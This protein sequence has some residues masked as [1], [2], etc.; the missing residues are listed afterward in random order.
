MER[1][2]EELRTDMPIYITKM[3]DGEKGQFTLSK[4]FAKMKVIDLVDSTY[5]DE[6]EDEDL[7]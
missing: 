6:D 4:D 1:P 2:D 3:R 5:I 7:I